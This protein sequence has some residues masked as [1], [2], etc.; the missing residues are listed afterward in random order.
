MKLLTDRI[1]GGNEEGSESKVP[2][3]CSKVSTVI[4]HLHKDNSLSAVNIQIY[5]LHL[6]LCKEIKDAV[7]CSESE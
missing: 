7:K 1:E 4:E 2:D 6:A 3:W 5:G